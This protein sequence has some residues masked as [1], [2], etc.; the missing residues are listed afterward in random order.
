MQLE[1]HDEHYRGE[2]AVFATTS[3]RYTNRAN[4]DHDVLGSSTF[5]QHQSHVIL[6]PT[7]IQLRGEVMLQSEAMEDG[8][9][10]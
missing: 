5:E 3:L 1:D 2:G 6:I 7:T 8:S 10:V 9:R 4:R